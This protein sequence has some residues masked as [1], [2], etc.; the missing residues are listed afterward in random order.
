M[1]TLSLWVFQVEGRGDTEVVK[2]HYRGRGWGRRNWILTHSWVKF[3]CWLSDS[4]IMIYQDNDLLVLALGVRTL[5][6]NKTVLSDTWQFA[7]YFSQAL[8]R[9]KS[10][11]ESTVVWVWLTLPLGCLPSVEFWPH[12]VSP[13]WAIDNSLRKGQ[14]LLWPSTFFSPSFFKWRT[15]M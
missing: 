15:K 5:L 6:P 10:L 11:W 7:G 13:C 12:F 14:V 2:D 1:T 4:R 9:F 8:A 3:W